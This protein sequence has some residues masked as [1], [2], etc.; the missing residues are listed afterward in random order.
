MPIT[1]LVYMCPIC[2]NSIEYKIE[3]ITIRSKCSRKEFKY[4][5]IETIFD[6]VSIMNSIKSP[7]CHHQNS[8]KYASSCDMIAVPEWTPALVDSLAEIFPDIRFI[9]LPKFKIFNDGS[10]ACR[11]HLKF[12]TDDTDSSIRFIKIANNIR[13]CNPGSPII[14]LNTKNAYDKKRRN[15]ITKN[16]ISIMSPNTS[17]AKSNEEVGIRFYKF[18]DS[19]IFKFKD[20]DQLEI[21]GV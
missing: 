15:S 13:K 8:N 12:I 17:I 9:D 5:E 20:Y 4:E 7:S 2:R 10:N 21:T 19:I 6:P 14:M 11:L 18:I 3:S 16:I 1:K